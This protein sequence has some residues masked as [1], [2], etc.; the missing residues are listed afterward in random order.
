[1]AGNNITYS[2]RRGLSVELYGAGIVIS[3]VEGAGFCESEISD[4]RLDGDTA[5]DFICRN[6]SAATNA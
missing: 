4:L 3:C 5:G 2:Y 1:M 6:T